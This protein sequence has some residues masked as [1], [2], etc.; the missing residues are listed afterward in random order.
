M[1]Y[2]NTSIHTSIETL[3]TDIQD[4]VDTASGIFDERDTY[5]YVFLGIV[6]LIIIAVIYLYNK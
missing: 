5:K 6:L 1:L 2:R 3:R 4:F